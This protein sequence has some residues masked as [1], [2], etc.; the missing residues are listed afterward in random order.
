[1][2][3]GM[4]ILSVPFRLTANGTLA[5]VSEGTDQANAEQISVILTTVQG[6]RLAQTGFG[7][8]DPVGSGITGGTVAAQVAKFGPANVTV[9]SVTSTPVTDGTT[10]VTVGFT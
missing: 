1:M 2:A 3:A 4:Q 6:E 7:L 9:T 5:T 8:P 10:D